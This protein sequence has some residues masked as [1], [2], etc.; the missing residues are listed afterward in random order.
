M[1]GDKVDITNLHRQTIFKEADVGKNKAECAA[2][3]LRALNPDIEVTA[4]PERIRHVD[5]IGVFDVILDG[6]DNFETKTLLNDISIALKTPLIG[7]SVE[8]FK[9]NVAV[10]AGSDADAPCY[11]CLFPELPIDCVNCNDA[12][13]LGT[14]PGLAGMYQAHLALCFLLGIGDVRPGTVLSLDFRT[15]RVQHLKLS[16]NPECGVC[17]KASYGAQRRMAIAPEIPLVHPDDLQNHII[18]DVRND[19]EVSADPITGALHIRLDTI[20]ARYGELPKDKLLA[21]ACVSNV[22]SRRAAEYLYGLGYTN[23]CVMDRLAG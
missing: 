21:F 1:D 12:G 4:L 15:M 6:T 17:K 10:F 20:P 3:Y 19:D 18:V 16:K 23:V 22:R 9:G 11:H 5:D 2:V 7:A 8:G 13:I 14:V